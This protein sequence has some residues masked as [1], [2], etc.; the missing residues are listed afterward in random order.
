MPVFAK[1]G[2][3]FVVELGGSPTTGYRWE[4]VDLPPGVEPAG[5]DVVTAPGARPGD[6][7]VQRL[8]FRALSPGRYRI[9]VRLRR[10]WEADPIETTELEVEIGAAEDSG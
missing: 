9:T 2:Q 10:S 8:R 5:G 1:V 3:V 7:A 4:A 6:A